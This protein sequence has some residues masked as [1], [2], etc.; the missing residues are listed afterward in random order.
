MKK[1]QYHPYRRIVCWLQGTHTASNRNSHHI[2]AKLKPIV[3]AKLYADMEQI[4][5]FGA[6]ALCH[7]ESSEKNFQAFFDYGNP[8]LLMQTQ[9]KHLLP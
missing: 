9:Q 1:A 4:L 8:N 7:G 6:L 5:L 2:L 3:P